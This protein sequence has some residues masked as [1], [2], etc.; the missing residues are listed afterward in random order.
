MTAMRCFVFY[1]VPRIHVS[2]VGNAS[3]RWLESSL[4]TGL[5]MNDNE[6][7][8][9]VDRLRFVKQGHPVYTIC[10]KHLWSDLGYTPGTAVVWTVHNA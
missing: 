6:T 9:G 2:S 4:R 10:L 7:V 8:T 3:W 5:R 1:H